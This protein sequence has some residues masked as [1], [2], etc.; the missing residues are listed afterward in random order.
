M[1]AY[2]LDHITPKS[3]RA[4]LNHS[5]SEP[6]VLEIN[7]KNTVR[8]IGIHKNESLPEKE[9]HQIPIDGSFQIVKERRKKTSCLLPEFILPDESG[10]AGRDRTDDPLLAKQVLSQLSYSP[11]LVFFPQG[12]VAVVSPRGHIAI[13]M[14]PCANRLRLALRKKSCARRSFAGTSEAGDVEHLIPASARTGT[15]CQIFADR[16]ARR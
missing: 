2:S 1:C 15:S 10:G 9:T 14:L 11:E 4:L 13:A 7:N 16:G 6:Y 8:H 12:C 5:L 3:L